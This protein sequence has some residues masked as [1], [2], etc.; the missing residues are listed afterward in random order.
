VNV[1]IV[2]T[3]SIQAPDGTPDTTGAIT[4]AEIAAGKLAADKVASVTAVTG[5]GGIMLPEV[6]L[7]EAG[8][9]VRNGIYEAWLPEPPSSNHYWRTRVARTRLGRTYVQTYVSPEARR[10][11]ENVWLLTRAAG[12][13]PLRGPVALEIAWYPRRG[14][15]LSNRVKVLEDALI[16]SAYLDDGQVC[17]IEAV[18]AAP[19]VRR[20]VRRYGVYVLVWET[21]Q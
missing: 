21:G 2:P 10:W 15:D 4:G 13:R 18:V 12:W 5:P 17:R 16:G 6:M 19:D 14:G 11:K 20:R 8:A 3:V 9:T 7:A 1:K